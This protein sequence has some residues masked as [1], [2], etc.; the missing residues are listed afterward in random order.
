[1][2]RLT[3]TRRLIAWGPV[4]A[5]IVAAC[6][7]GMGWLVTSI[8]DMVVGMWDHPYETAIIAWVILLLY[9]WDK[10]FGW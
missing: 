4:V 5:A 6:V 7:M 3:T 2:S 1:M 9:S 10:D 8:P